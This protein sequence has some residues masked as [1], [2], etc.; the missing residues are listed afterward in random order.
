MKFEMG[1]R[2]ITIANLLW[3]S[4]LLVK[5]AEIPPDL[6]QDEHFREEL[7]VNEFTAP[8]IEKILRDIEMLRPIPYETIRRE[9]PANPPSDR[10]RV[11][12]SI[13]ALIA[14]G[15]ALVDV[16]NKD[17]VELLARA[18]LK[19]ARALSVIDAI[20]P[21]AQSLAEKGMRGN[22]QELKEELARAQADAEFA[23]L[24]LRDD[25]VAH[26]ISLGGWVRALEICS[27]AILQKY[28]AE[29]ASTLVRLD[30]MDYFIDR[31]ETLHPSIRNREVIQTTVA[32]LKTIRQTLHRP[33]GT[34]IYESDVRDIY[35]RSK[36]IIDL[37][38]R[39]EGKKSNE[40]TSEE[41]SSTDLE[42]P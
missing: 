40:K 2:F 21:R 37:M 7:G 16:Q 41:T 20:M 27:A 12:L 26:L 22:W 1:R 9:P 14:Q 23:M 33:E 4:I 34:S 5:G 18:L 38:L 15:F 36:R 8:S 19:H 31:L 30:L 25:E 17:D 24:K 35:A 42:L 11:A 39:D 32:E 28:T 10:V 29:K 6:L 3:I 13:G